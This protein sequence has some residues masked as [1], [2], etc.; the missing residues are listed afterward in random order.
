V[1]D[2]FG[3]GL[4]WTFIG[5]SA[6]GHSRQ[7]ECA[8]D[9]SAWG[10]PSDVL[11]LRSELALSANNKHQLFSTDYGIAVQRESR[12]RITTNSAFPAVVATMSPPW[13]QDKP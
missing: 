2:Q 10:L 4:R 1:F 9:T 6:L 12:V 8:T 11:L 13:D 7:F 5:R 3:F